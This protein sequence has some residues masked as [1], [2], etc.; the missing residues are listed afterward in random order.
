MSAH[1]DAQWL[2]GRL[3]HQAG[4]VER[5]V[6]DVSQTQAVWKPVPDQWSILEVVCHLA[7]EEVLDFRTRLALVLR[8]PEADWPPIDPPGWAVERRYNE[9][10]LEDAVAGFL[11]ER[12]ASVAWLRGLADPDW[13]ATH[14]HPQLGPL[15]ARD[16]AASWAAHD[17]LHVRQITRLRFQYLAVDFPDGDSGYAG[18]W[19]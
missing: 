14:T 13:T 4:I 9:R 15:R 8:D 19:T 6:G 16:L 2:A 18:R 3:H 10:E 1:R 7:D 11:G 17:L 12:A 5:L